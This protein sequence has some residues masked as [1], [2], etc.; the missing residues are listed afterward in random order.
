MKKKLIIEGTVTYSDGTKYV[1]EFK[2]GMRHGQ[3]I[4]TSIGELLKYVG[5]WKDDKKHGKGTYTWSDGE[6]YTGE[7]REG[8]LIE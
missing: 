1:G 7:W 3:G 4:Y 2:D 6:K 8:E 5:E